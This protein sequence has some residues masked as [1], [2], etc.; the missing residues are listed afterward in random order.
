MNVVVFVS[1]SHGGELLDP[2]TPHLS[3]LAQGIGRGD[4]IF[5]VALYTHGRINKLDEHLWR[6]RRSAGL[7]GLDIP[8][9]DAW[10]AAIDR[11]MQAWEP[12]ADAESVP[13][14]AMI[15]LSVIR[16][17]APENP[18]GYAWVNI[19][20]M[21]LSRR[22]THPIRV[23][24]LERGIDSGLAA[25]APW[26]LIGAKTLSYA[27]NMA[28]LREAEARGAEDAIFTTTD[29]YILEAPTAT[30]IIKRGHELITPPVEIGVL[31]GTTQRVLYRAAAEA[32][33]ATSYKMLTPEDLFTADAV[34]LASSARLLSQVGRIDDR[35]VR[36][37]DA[38]HAEISRLLDAAM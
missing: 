25:R 35:E 8:S 2:S 10:R 30:V 15:K 34:W 16:G 29:G 4:G 1:D 19:T 36:I 33:W 26:L 32:G 17:Y 5:E 21:P 27:T 13:G 22:T 38:A 24:L 9:D 12:V 14:E 28:A 18:E 31:P 37:D 11:G 20:P 7:L 3:A 23:V 6:L